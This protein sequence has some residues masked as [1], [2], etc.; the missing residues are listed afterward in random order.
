LPRDYEILYIVRPELDEQQVQEAV[1]SVNRLIENVQGTVLK[2]DVWGKRKLAYE[3]RHLREGTYVLTD[4]RVEP[5]RIPEVEATIKISDAVFRHLIVRK[6]D[7]PRREKPQQ[8]KPA[9]ERAEAQEMGDEV[10]EPVAEEQVD[11]PA[12]EAEEAEEP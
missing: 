8:A 1:A 5:D 9:S 10:P 11:A 4:F 3:V 12:G 2:T 6:P 7:R